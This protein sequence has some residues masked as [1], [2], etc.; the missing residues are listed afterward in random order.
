MTEPL[1]HIER[2]KVIRSYAEE[3]GLRNFVETGTAEGFTMANLIDDFD[4]LTTVEIDKGLCLAARERFKD[5]AKVC[6]VNADSGQFLKSLVPYM[7]KPTLFWLDGHYCGGPGRGDVDTPIAS[8]LCAVL[9]APRGSVILIDD[10]RLFDGME[11]HTEE[12]SDYPHWQWVER[13][14]DICDYAC[15]IEDDIFRLTPCELSDDV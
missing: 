5:H 4:W 1:P 9:Q 3:F 10:A 6:C 15:I 7:V 13:M 12:F 11:D 8:E 2:V 14:A